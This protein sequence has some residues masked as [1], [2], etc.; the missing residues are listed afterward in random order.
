MRDLYQES[1]KF[2]LDFV[3][4]T[5]EPI[6]TKGERAGY[7]IARHAARETAGAL[8]EEAKRLGLT[9]EQQEALR[10]VAADVAYD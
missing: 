9:A 5:E 1:V 2:G 6:G 10:V 7:W 8:L 4:V 3:G